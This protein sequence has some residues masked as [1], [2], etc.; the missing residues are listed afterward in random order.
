[1]KYIMYV[2]YIWRS[3]TILKLFLSSKDIVNYNF[4]DTKEHLTANY[5]F[6]HNQT[7]VNSG[8]DYLIFLGYRKQG[9]N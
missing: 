9:Y 4:S 1:M 6:A 3:R 7:G 2:R 8:N 5:R